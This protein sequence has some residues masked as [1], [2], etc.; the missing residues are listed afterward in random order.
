MVLGYFWIAYAQ[1]YNCKFVA[2]SMTCW[3]VGLWNML[4]N[5]HRF[6]VVCHTAKTM[7][8]W[9][10]TLCASC[11]THF[12]TWAICGHETDRFDADCFQRLIRVHWIHVFS[13]KQNSGTENFQ[14]EHC[15]KEH[16]GTRKFQEYQFV[17]EFEKLFLEKI[18]GFYFEQGRK[19]QDFRINLIPGVKIFWQNFPGHLISPGL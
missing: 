6:L 2:T 10:L 3:H 13:V 15:R 18:P 11:V 7:W 9:K 8:P 1:A 17:M 12:D 14:T 5:K 16:L 19:F 4:R